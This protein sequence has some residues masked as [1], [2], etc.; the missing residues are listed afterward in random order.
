MAATTSSSSCTSIFG[1]RSNGVDPR[2][3]TPS[4]HGSS[5]PGCTKLDGVAMWFINGVAS[6]FFA[7]LDRC[8]CVRIATVDDAEEANDTPL[9]LYDG[10]ARY[11][12]ATNISR[13]RK[14]KGGNS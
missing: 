6:A 7:S 4:S 13:R 14:G 9:I 10:N 1:F 11:Q 2:G 3:R 5:S 8:S 12:A